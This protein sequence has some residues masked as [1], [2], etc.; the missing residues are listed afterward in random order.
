MRHDQL[1]RRDFLASLAAL[2]TAI[3]VRKASAA[4][5]VSQAHAP[6]FMYVGSYTSEGRGHGEGISVFERSPT[7]ALGASP[8]R[9]NRWALIQV[10]K[11]LADPSF[12]IV[13]RQRRHL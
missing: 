12:V 4:Q 7:L 9:S 3:A 5:T 8:D 13:D 6:T 1:Y 10:V 2:T 11:E